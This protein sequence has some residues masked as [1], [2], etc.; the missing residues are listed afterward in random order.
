MDQ[1]PQAGRRHS[2]TGG[3]VVDALGGWETPKRG[4]DARVDRERRRQQVSPSKVC[5]GLSCDLVEIGDIDP[6]PPGTKV[7]DGGGIERDGGVPAGAESLEPRVDEHGDVAD[8]AGCAVRN[9]RREYHPGRAPAGTLAGRPFEEPGLRHQDRPRGMRV[10][11]P[12]ST[13]GVTEDHRVVS[14][15]QRGRSMC[16]STTTD[17]GHVDWVNRDAGE[18]AIAIP[19][20]RVRVRWCYWAR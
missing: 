3:E 11:R 20:P 19:M 10:L 7:L 1:C 15:K 2:D 14:G 9:P 6:R 5:H 12:T 13:T 16:T 18:R 17:V 8:G 4:R